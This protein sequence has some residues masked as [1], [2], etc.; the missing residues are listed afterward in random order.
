MLL[1]LIMQTNRKH[2]QCIHQC[3]DHEHVQRSFITCFHYLFCN[4]YI[5]VSHGKQISKVCPWSLS[6]WHICLCAFFLKKEKLAR[7]DL[8][9]QIEQFFVIRLVA[10]FQ[11]RRVFSVA[12][13]G[14]TGIIVFLIFNNLILGFFHSVQIS[15]P[16]L[17]K[18]E[19]LSPQE[20]LFI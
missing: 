13:L 19:P 11:Y 12:L 5:F 14:V 1:H 3:L 6:G 17:L 9:S 4:V 8:V 20:P 18:S 2:K 10:F 15:F 16:K 7:F